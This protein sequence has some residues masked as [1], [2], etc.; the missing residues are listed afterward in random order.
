MAS[1]I[2]GQDNSL[3]AATESSPYQVSAIE[4]LI[5]EWVPVTVA[6]NAMNRSIGQPDFY[7]F[8]LSQAI[9]EK[10]QFVLHVI[11]A[12]RPI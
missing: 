5:K 11:H 7:P 8:V 10:L 6:M 4:A 1:Q 3:S 12:N 9:S 2:I